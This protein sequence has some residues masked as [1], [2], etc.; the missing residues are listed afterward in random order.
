MNTVEHEQEPVHHAHTAQL[1][2]CEGV[3][4]VG[5]SS[6]QPF[7]PSLCALSFALCVFSVCSSLC[8]PLCRPRPPSLAV[9]RQQA[10]QHAGITVA[11]VCLRVCDDSAGLRSGKRGREENG[12]T[13]PRET[14]P[15]ETEQSMRSWETEH[16]VMGDRG[17]PAATQTPTR[18]TVVTARSSTSGARRAAAHSRDNTSHQ[19]NSAH[20]NLTPNAHHALTRTHPSCMLSDSG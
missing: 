16:A 18:H 10:A 12:N 9:G 17:E 3:V 14:E 4:C 5:T 11:L 19:H 8:L 20:G 2:V 6:G 13:E 1:L 15:R 7:A